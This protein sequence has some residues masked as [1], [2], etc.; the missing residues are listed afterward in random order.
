M[1]NP[2][3]ACRREMRIPRVSAVYPL[4]VSRLPLP[5]HQGAYGALVASQL[6]L[7]TTE[8]GFEASMRV[9]VP[10]NFPSFIRPTARNVTFGVPFGSV[11]SLYGFDV[12]ITLSASTFVLMATVT[13]VFA[14]VTVAVV[15][16]VLLTVKVVVVVSPSR[17]DVPFHVPAMSAA[18]RAGG[19]GGG[20]GGAGVVVSGAGS[21]L[22]HAAT[23][24]AR[25]NTL[26]I[27]ASVGDDRIRS[28]TREST[29]THAPS[30]MQ[31]RTVVR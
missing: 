15:S 23:N 4:P 14:N 3:D 31:P 26:R 30:I 24:R 16:E 22:A 12:E 1:R 10:T 17:F 21:F 20:G 28:V 5:G 13:L 29:A 2:Q 18:V 27:D 6:A 25:K 19:G 8:S 11:G 7:P 9:V